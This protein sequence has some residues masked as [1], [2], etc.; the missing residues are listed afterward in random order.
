MS[1]KRTTTSLLALFVALLSLAVAALSFLRMQQL[2]ED[3]EAKLAEMEA[4][5]AQLRQEI[6]HTATESAAPDSIRADLKN[7]DLTAVPWYDNSGASVTLT[8]IPATY[9]PGLTAEFLVTLEGETAARIPCSWNGT[10]FTATAEL[11]ARDGYSYQCLLNSGDTTREI[12]LASADNPAD[13]LAVYLAQSLHSYCSLMLGDWS[14]DGDQLNLSSCYLQ[15]Q[16]PQIT[17]D[18]RTAGCEVSKLTLRLG[19]EV[20]R[21]HWVTLNPGEASHCYELN[22]ENLSFLLPA[23]EEGDHL[24]LWLEITVSDGQLLTAAGG[25]WDYLDGNLQ[26]TAG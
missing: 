9:Q 24:E 11:T 20:L 16:L 8:A 19:E 15:A 13:T 3:Y 4:I 5:H 25:S 21:T 2:Q 23:L 18:G 7:W 6:E 26:L 10:A 1:K 22:L 17:A 14:T 12:L